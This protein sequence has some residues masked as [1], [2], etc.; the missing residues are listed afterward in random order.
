[1]SGKQSIGLNNPDFQ[2]AW[3]EVRQD[4]SDANWYNK[5]KKNFL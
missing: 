1:M 3:Q 5:I 2:Q 4:S